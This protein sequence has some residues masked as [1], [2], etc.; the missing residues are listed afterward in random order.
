M[1]LE[2]FLAS[3][4]IIRGVVAGKSWGPSNATAPDF[5]GIEVQLI[6]TS[7]AAKLALDQLPI[8]L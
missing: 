8:D 4:P 3:Y 2:T 6:G 5:I 7:S 1:V